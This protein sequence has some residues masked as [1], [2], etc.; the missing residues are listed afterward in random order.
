MNRE[1]GFYWV[2]FNEGDKPEI[3]QFDI[4]GW[5][6]CGLDQLFSGDFHWISDSPVIIEE[7]SK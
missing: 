7:P 2:I 5:W 3:A 6:F 1:P 4:G